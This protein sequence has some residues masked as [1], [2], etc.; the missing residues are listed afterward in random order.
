MDLWIHYVAACALLGR[1]SVTHQL[2]DEDKVC[3][4]EAMT[5]CAARSDGRLAVVE[6]GNGYSLEPTGRGV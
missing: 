3:V 5:D 6:A 2:S 1:L 4:G